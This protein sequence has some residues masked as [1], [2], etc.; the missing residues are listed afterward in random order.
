MKVLHLALSAAP[1]EVMVTGEKPFEFRKD[2]ESGWMRKRLFNKDGTE[3]KY[4]HIKFTHGY[5]VNRPYFICEYFGF[6]E[7]DI[8]FLIKYSNGLKVDIEIGDFIIHC[9]PIVEYGNLK[10]TKK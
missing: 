3:K 4:T 1:F 2:T 5:G 9:G 6:E 10:T 8:S 7:S